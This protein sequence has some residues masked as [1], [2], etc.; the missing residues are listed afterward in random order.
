MISFGILVVQ[1][2]L[3]S[4]DE[5]SL[6]YLG[7]NIGFFVSINLFIALQNLL[8]MTLWTTVHQ[9]LCGVNCYVVYG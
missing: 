3:H 7:G 2:A 1:Q 9:L 4:F 5:G 8:T 6:I